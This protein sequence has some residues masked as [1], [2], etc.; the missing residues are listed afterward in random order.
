MED[1]NQL[2]NTALGTT[3]QN[4]CDSAENLKKCAEIFYELSDKDNTA[5][6][7]SL[8]LFPMNASEK[9]T[10]DFWFQKYK[11]DNRYDEFDFAFDV[12]RNYILYIS[13]KDTKAFNSR[14]I[15]NARKFGNYKFFS[16]FLSAVL[17]YVDELMAIGAYLTKDALYFENFLEL[18]VSPEKIQTSDFI[19]DIKKQIRFKKEYYKITRKY[20]ELLNFVQN[21]ESRKNGI[22]Q[23]LNKEV[24]NLKEQI[25]EL[26]IRLDKIDLRDTINMS[27]KYL[28]NILRTKF[29][30]EDY[31]NNFWDQVREIKKILSRKEYSKY[32]F[33]IRF[34]DDMEFTQLTDLNKAAHHS[35]GKKRKFSDIKKYMQYTS[36]DDLNKV[37]EFF[38]ALP[39][40]DDF[41]Q[42]HLSHFFNPWK[43]EEK[44]KTLVDY[45]KLFNELFKFN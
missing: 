26:R 25:N 9:N 6:N 3:N 40:I 38:N 16:D 31:A 10:K 20:N 39:N 19:S 33:I 8:Y 23:N 7:V 21:S 45:N 32:D 43:A 15:L 34:I 35:E 44:F 27:F 13:E 22:I 1:L 36:N 29:N 12:L 24:I 5:F 42:L 30:T 17:D 28:Y 14:I 41:I 37:V 4:Y 11:D 18:K 2:L